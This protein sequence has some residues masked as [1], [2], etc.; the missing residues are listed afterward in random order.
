[1][2]TAVIIALIALGGCMMLIVFNPILKVEKQLKFFGSFPY[3]R[4]IDSSNGVVSVSAHHGYKESPEYVDLWEF[5]VR[6]KTSKFYQNTDNGQKVSFEGTLEDGL[7]R[8]LSKKNLLPLLYVSFK[9]FFQSIALVLS[10]VGALISFGYLFSFFNDLENFDPSRVLYSV[11]IPWWYKI[12]GDSIFYKSGIGI[13][14]FVSMILFIVLT[15][16]FDNKLKKDQ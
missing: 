11:D 2:L 9:K 12:T 6:N 15:F 14:L 8:I 3:W 13:A 5:D 10:G 16:M 7:N 4:S 1:M